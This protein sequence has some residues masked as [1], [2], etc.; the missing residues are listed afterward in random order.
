MGRLPRR[1]LVGQ[2]NHPV[3]RFGG[4]RRDA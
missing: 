2:L 1:R 4:Q 3:D